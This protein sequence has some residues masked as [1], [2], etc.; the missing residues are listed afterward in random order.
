MESNQYA[1][2]EL[3]E[4]IQVIQKRIWYIILITILATAV[5][6]LISFFVISPQYQAA[7]ELLVNQDQIEGQVNQGDIRTNLELIGTYQVVMTSPRILDKVI[8]EHGLDKTYQGLKNQIN[9]NTIRNSQVMKITVTDP[10]YEQAVFIVNALARTFQKE[11]VTLMN[12]DNV[13]IMAEAKEM[14]SPSPVSPKPYLNMAIAF[15]VGLMTAIG[16][17]FVLEF[18]DNTLKREQDIEKMLGLP[19]LGAIPTMDEQLEK[20]GNAK[21]AVQ[22]G[23]EQ[24]ET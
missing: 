16:L 11:I 19:V 20:S 8:E 5:S 1:E 2:V 18:L 3:R 4:L 21:L 6:G 13:H 24:L 9:V 23:G 12:I 15:V 10:N 7:T 22:M 17:V 14:A